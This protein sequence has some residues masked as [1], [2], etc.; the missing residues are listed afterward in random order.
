MGAT[1]IARQMKIGRSTVYRVLGNS[2]PD[3]AVKK[4][5]IDINMR[6]KLHN[7]LL[8]Q[9]EIIDDIP[10]DQENYIQWLKV[11]KHIE[12]LKGNASD[13]ELIIYAS[14]RCTFIHAA[15][16]PNKLLN[17]DNIDLEDLLN[18]SG[19]PFTNRADYT[20]QPGKNNVGVTEDK[21]I[22]VSNSL[23]DAHLL[24]FGRTLYDWE[25]EDHCEF[26]LLQEYAHLNGIHWRKEH[27][28]YCNYDESGDIENVVS[29]T[30][31]FGNEKNSLITFLRKPLEQY[32]AATDSVLVQMFDFC[33]FDPNNF[34]HWS[35]IPAEIV[36][37][38]RNFAYR[39]HIEP[40]A[41]YARGVQIIQP[42]R[43]REKIFSELMNSQH[44][45]KHKQFVEFIAIDWR[46]DQITEI[47]TDPVST[48]NYFE[49][50]KNDL[51]FE[52]S[53]A[54]FNPEVLLKYKG[55]PD[56]YVIDSR[57][58]TCRNSWHLR[59]FDVNEERQIHAYICDLRHLPD[60]EQLY[61]KSFNEIPKAG[62][63]KR[64]LANDF[65]GQSY[66]HVEPHQK[67]KFILDGW[68]NSNVGWWKL[69]DKKLLNRINPPLTTSP[70]EWCEEF[71]N[72]SKLIVEGFDLKVIRCR[73]KLDGIEYKADEKSLKLLEKLISNKLPDHAVC[74]LAGLRS[75]QE[76][77]TKVKGHVGGSDKK[78]ISM[79]ALGEHESYHQHYEHVCELVAQELVDIDSAFSTTKLKK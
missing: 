22:E 27:G 30:N 4:F 73:L 68:E 56:K 45:M 57:S 31:N 53:P 52:L 28:G 65:K 13:N 23:K 66:A 61:W 6:S 15:V 29:I 41:A 19:N 48:T 58:I 26:E 59:R 60:S 40:I 47:S 33:L 50:D 49:A 75:V 18:W 67:V 37:E 71:M 70:E 24:I 21:F 32:L 39:Q 17:T 51:P 62:I 46:N 35:D 55:D 3:S 12:Y 64:A 14:G 1:A 36:R 69:R 42:R 77:R 5:V 43:A 76:V 72:L 10:D 63:S 7:K 74:T 79:S 38:S 9:I 8:N 54:F 2:R 44:G 20:W 34:S 11:T 16:V 78:K 25:D